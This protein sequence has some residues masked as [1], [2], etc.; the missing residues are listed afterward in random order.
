M[1]RTRKTY[2]ENKIEA[3][4]G[5]PSRRCFVSFLIRWER[6]SLQDAKDIR[7]SSLP[8]SLRVSTTDLRPAL[9]SRYQTLNLPLAQGP[10]ESKVHAPVRTQLEHVIF[11][12]LPMYGSWDSEGL[13]TELMW[14]QTMYSLTSLSIRVQEEA[15]SSYETARCLSA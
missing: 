9:L 5:D 7:S 3:R 6:G 1:D 2:G 15:R 8:E 10:L 14:Q 11:K 4:C 12:S 13:Q